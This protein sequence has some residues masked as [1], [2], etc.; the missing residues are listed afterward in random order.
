MSEPWQALRLFRT[1]RR[2]L[3]EANI[4]NSLSL[5]QRFPANPAISGGGP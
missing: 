5:S 2:W 1:L 3:L 4:R